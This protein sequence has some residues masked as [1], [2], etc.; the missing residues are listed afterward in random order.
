MTNQMQQSIKTCMC[1]LQH[2]GGLSKAPLHPMVA[3]TP[4]DLLHVDFTSKGTT[5][6]LNK[7]PKVANILVF[8]DHFKKHVLAYMTPNQTAKTVTKYLYQGYIS[9]FR[10]PVRFLS[11]R[12]ANFMSSVINEMC[13]I[14]GM[15]KLQTIPYHPD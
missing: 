9:I 1:C 2:E 7:S 15:K 14:L 4:L 5:L 8:Q 3:T 6:E 12:S 13:K 11:D 10:A